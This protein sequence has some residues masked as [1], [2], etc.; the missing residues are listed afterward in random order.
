MKDYKS[1]YTIK[2]SSECTKLLVISKSKLEYFGGKEYYNKILLDCFLKSI[3]RQSKIFSLFKQYALNDNSNREKISNFQIDLENQVS[4]QKNTRNLPN[5]N[6]LLK[7][8]L[9]TNDK[10]SNRKKSLQESIKELKE[11]C[12]QISLFIPEI[13]KKANNVSFRMNEEEIG[14]NKLFEKFSLKIYNKDEKIEVKKNHCLI[15]LYGKMIDLSNN[16]VI[17]LYSLLSFITNSNYNTKYIFKTKCFILQGELNN[18]I[19]DNQKDESID[20]LKEMKKNVKWLSSLP[21]E[22]LKSVSNLVEKEEFFYSKIV[23]ELDKPIDSIIYISKGK[24]LK[25]YPLSENIKVTELYENYEDNNK[26][27]NITKVYTEGDVID[28]LIETDNNKF[29][30]IADNKDSICV[31]YKINKDII[32]CLL[33]SNMIN[34]LIKEYSTINDISKENIRL[35]DIKLIA[36]I[37][38]GAYGIVNLVKYNNSMYA[39]KSFSKEKI[40]NKPNLLK[41]LIDERHNTKLLK[42][43]FTVKYYNSIQD[44]TSI[45]LLFEYVKGVPLESLI[46]KEKL[47]NN[48]HACIFIYANLIIALNCL[49]KNNILHRDIKPDNI[50]ID[51]EGFVKMIDFGLSKKITSFTYTIIGTPFYM[52]PEVIKGL[53]Y[54]KSCDF[55]SSA[56][57]LYRLF[58]NRYPFGDRYDSVMEVY[59]KIIK[60]EVIYPSVDCKHIITLKQL[61]KY[62]LIKKPNDRLSSLKDAKKMLN[63]LNWTD[64]IIL[65]LN[66]PIKSLYI[67]NQLE[68]YNNND[69]SDNTYNGINFDQEIINKH[70][71]I[72]VQNN[73]IISKNDL[74]DLF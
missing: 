51:S 40:K 27:V 35:N 28:D 23:K 61:L 1:R 71:G 8:D 53:G 68:F 7:I 25:L 67:N 38:K 31:V 66:S 74:Y 13:R 16:I 39:L 65:K 33:G 73:S 57:V 59:S 11:E 54:S 3:K 62:A 63:N 60:S 36:Y 37:G 46:K 9:L 48:Y 41:Y 21:S 10:T 69:T 52:A 42:S 50:L 26:K 14:F 5:E 17:K 22:I 47:Y 29:A 20:V 15:L 24:L 45:H 44:N 72:K 32:R 58:Y 2:V 64:M 34:F 30:I 6:K 55:W 4:K 12:E 19:S 56:V 43:P 18:L 70:F 49:N